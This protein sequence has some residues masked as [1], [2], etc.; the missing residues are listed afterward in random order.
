[1]FYLFYFAFNVSHLWDYPQYFMFVIKY[2][3]FCYWL[4]IILILMVVFVLK[5]VIIGKSRGYVEVS[6]VNHAD[7]VFSLFPFA[8]TFGFPITP[9]NIGAF[10]EQWLRLLRES[11][12]ET[13]L[14]GEKL[15]TNVSVRKVVHHLL[16]G[17][18]KH[19]TCYMEE[20]TSLEIENLCNIP[21]ENKKVS[22]Y[23]MKE[24]ESLKLFLLVQKSLQT[25][26]HCARQCSKVAKEKEILKHI[27]FDKYISICTQKNTTAYITTV[28]LLSFPY[29]SCKNVSGSVG[30]LLRQNA[31]E[32]LTQI[33][34]HNLRKE[35][36]ILNKKL[37][38]LMKVNC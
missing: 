28:M 32:S 36:S 35:I 31:E 20:H 10:L 33:H 24:I 17:I 22:T 15:A 1:M 3:L 6:K 11:I 26:G 12:H 25:V 37:R 2:Y 5:F 8:E 34:D 4:L 13:V 38:L 27:L 18:G 9:R 16:Q 30:E 7:H 19:A 21:D 29:E 23:I 14:D